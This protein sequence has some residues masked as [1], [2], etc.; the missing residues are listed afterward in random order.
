VNCNR[1]DALNIQVEPGV[2]RTLS[3]KDAEWMSSVATFE[4]P[5]SISDMFKGVD[6]V[7]PN[8]PPAAIRRPFGFGRIPGDPMSGSDVVIKLSDLGSIP[9]FQFF[10]VS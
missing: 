5:M 6:N 7:R 4:A 8:V 10:L 9:S 3:P 1:P 2:R